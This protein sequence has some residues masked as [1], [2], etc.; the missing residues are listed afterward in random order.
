VAIFLGHLVKIFD[1]ATFPIWMLTV[2]LPSTSTVPMCTSP[3]R[4]TNH[5][6]CNDALFD[7][8]ATSPFPDRVLLLDNTDLTSPL[9]EEDGLRDAVAVIAM[10]IFAIAGD[11]VKS[12]RKASQ[13]G[14]KDGL[15][16]NGKIEP[17][18]DYPIYDFNS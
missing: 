2:N 7:L 17:N 9:L 10:R 5:H 3:F 8:F 4:R 16:R 1:D 12:W 15:Q 14:V 6:P 13:K 11:Q 18:I